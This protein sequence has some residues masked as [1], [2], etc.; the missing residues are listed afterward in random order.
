MKRIHDAGVV[1][2]GF[3]IFDVLVTNTKPFII[4]F[5]NASEKVCERRLD[6]VNGAIAPTREQFGCAELYRHC[7]D[8]RTWKPRKLLITINRLR[9]VDRPSYRHLHRR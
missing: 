6:I 8:L 1:H 9:L 5:K 4:N 3:G 7:V 2:G